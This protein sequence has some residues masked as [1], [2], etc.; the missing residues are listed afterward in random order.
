MWVVNLLLLILL[1]FYLALMLYYRLQWNALPAFTPSLKLKSLPKISVIIAARNEEKNIAEC[2]E[3]IAYQTYPRSHYEIIVVDDYSTDHTAHI[4]NR[5]A[6]R[7][8]NVKLLQMRDV[9]NERDIVSYKKM[10]LSTG[11]KAAQGSIILCTDADC[12][13]V[14]EWIYTIVSCMIENNLKMVAAPVL[15]HREV[16]FFQGFQALDMIGLMGVTGASLHS[17]LSYMCN[18]ANLAYYKEVYDEVGGFDDISVL[19]SGDDLMLMYKIAKI[20]PNNITFC[21]SNQAVVKTC[22]NRTWKNFFQQRIRWATKNARLD[23][24]RIPWL[25][26]GV[27]G[28]NLVLVINTIIEW[29][30]LH[31][32]IGLSLFA[33][34][35]KAL[36]D[37]FFLNNLCDFFK[38]KSLMNYFLISLFLHVMYINIIGIM[39]TF[40][41]TYKWKGRLSK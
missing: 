26:A 30:I 8:H 37:Y 7:L 16:N 39:A 23:D 29:G 14:P 10:A 6:A 36:I 24:R 25:L 31:R 27:L 5:Y 9:M 40:K 22:A 34:I 35:A 15:Y 41:K 33:W 28:F 21:K 3:S 11:I 2:L 1:V 20:Y 19:A 32:I 17:R 12:I 18:G 13:S 38:R 4:V